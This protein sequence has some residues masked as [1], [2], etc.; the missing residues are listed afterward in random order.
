[1]FALLAGLGRAV[2][3]DYAPAPA[4]NPVARVVVAQGD[5]LLQAFLPDEAQLA[6]VFERGLTD[7]TRT[8][9]ALAAWRTLVKTNDVVGIKVFSEPGP[10][11]GT[12]PALVAVLVRSL[13]AAGVPTNRIII[14]DKRADDLHQAGFDRLGAELGVAVVGALETG[15]D[16]NVFYL[17]DSPV[18]G[19]LVWGDSEFQQKGEGLGKKSYVSRLVSQR[20]TKIISVA[21]LINEPAAGVCGHFYSLG[22][23]SVDNTRRFEGDAG[24]LAVAL[25][26]LIALPQLGDRVALY[27]TDAL[28][29]Q[30]QG[31][32]ASF[33]QYSTVLNEVWFSHDPVA[34]DMLAMQQVVQEQKVG[35]APPLKMNFE[36]YTNAALLQLGIQNPARIQVETVR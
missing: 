20:L 25:P 2:A 29:G 17:P 26:E 4:T 12:R 7:F 36:I 9:T 5:H 10:L 11:M 23:G 3:M 21:P 34:L 35:H 16:T 6:P 32:P 31:G 13:L 24:R 15:Y 27:V 18:M 28:L 1:L 30:S 33:L 8:T 19:S 22:L 14:W